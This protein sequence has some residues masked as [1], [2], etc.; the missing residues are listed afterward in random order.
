MT[1]E[2]KDFKDNSK[3]KKQATTKSLKNKKET[4][5]IEETRL[6]KYLSHNTKYSRRE[7]D[8]LIKEGKIKVDDEVVIDLG[9][10]VTYK[11]KVYLRDKL[12]YVDKHR[13]I[14]VVVYNKQKGEIVSKNDPQGRRTIFDTLSK[15][16][17]HFT[18]I[19]R[20]DYGS[21]GVLLLSDD[22]KVADKLMHGDLERIYKL[23]LDGFIT[24]S[25]EKAMLEGLELED[26]TKG[27]RSDSKITSMSFA[28]FIGYTIISSAKKYSKIKVA[29]SEGK[30]RELRRF[31]AHFDLNVLDLK[32]LEFGGISL[33]NLP[34]GKVRYLSRE[35]YRNL[36]DYIEVDKE[37]K[38]NRKNKNDRQDREDKQYE[39]K[40]L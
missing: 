6:N 36:R 1:N 11:N 7:A 37:H 16:F 28:P 25:I 35:E 26:A 12:V 30:N 3:F 4:E 34:S 40:D 9:T 14:T 15:R 13:K 27:A 32:R 21:E 38:F 17:A 22:V 29:I 20:L 33:N 10:K 18:P 24:P 8:E 23:K 39:Q 2:N 5:E 31:F 19:G